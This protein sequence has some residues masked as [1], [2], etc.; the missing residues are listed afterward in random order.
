MPATSYLVF[1]ETSERGTWT[2]VGTY[3][4]ASGDSAIRAAAV[5]HG[6]GTYAATPSRGWQPRTVKVEAKASFEKTS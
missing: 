6:E 4:A 5:S 2:T 3:D 1:E